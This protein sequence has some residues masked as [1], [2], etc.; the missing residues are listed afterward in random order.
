V[1][2]DDDIAGRR[3]ARVYRTSGRGDLHD[4]LCESVESAGGKV[5]YASSPTRAPIY[6]GVEVGDEER[7]GLLCY[8]FL[9]TQRAI[10]NRPADEH[11][12]QIRYGSELSWTE[13]HPLGL[14]I[15]GV[16]TTLVL[17]VHLAAGIIVGL[18]PLLYNPL[19]MGI[20]IEFKN[21]EVEVL[22]NTG[23]HSWERGNVSGVR[24]TP[25][26]RSGI[27]TLTGFIPE[28]LIDYA[29]FEREAT[30]L[31]LDPVL[32]MRAAHAVGSGTRGPTARHLLEETFHLE[33]RE[34]MEI[35]S[36]RR[37]LAVAVRGGVAEHHLMRELEAD[38]HVVIVE[39]VDEE[40]PPDAIATLDDGRRVRVECKNGSFYANGEGRVEVQKTRASKGNPASRYYEVTQFDVLAV[41]LWPDDGGSPRFVYRATRDLQ[42][43]PEFPDRLAVLHRIGGDWSSNLAQALS[44]P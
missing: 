4:F 10:R 18:D 24:R 19:P 14:D 2:G 13:D 17:G 35:I 37:R 32:R 41:C 11:R 28:R 20:S 43:H 30:S 9:A 38:P 1:A 12:M 44:D 36:S 23:W 42:R 7:L 6:L 5:I 3:Y 31:A 16:D 33:S 26:S 27:E 8:P 34:I 29:R 39:Q 40:G 21:A 25:R 22:R 15:A